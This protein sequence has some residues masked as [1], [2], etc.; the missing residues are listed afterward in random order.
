MPERIICLE[1]E[2]AL[3]QELLEE[4]EQKYRRERQQSDDLRYALFMSQSARQ[5]VAPQR[6]QSH[7]Q[8]Y[9]QRRVSYVEHKVWFCSSFAC[10]RRSDLHHHLQE[11]LLRR[12]ARSW[13]SSE[14]IVHALGTWC[15]V[16]TH[17]IRGQFEESQ[18]VHDT[19]EEQSSRGTVHK[20]NDAQEELLRVTGEK[21]ALEDK[22]NQT[23]ARLA[24]RDA[25]YQ[26][27]LSQLHALQEMGCVC[28]GQ[29]MHP[30]LGKACT[31]SEA[32]VLAND[33]APSFTDS[34]AVSAVI[35]AVCRSC[36]DLQGVIAGL[37]KVED[38][39]IQR[40]KAFLASERRA[41]V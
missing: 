30:K 26:V 11:P 39:I 29:G 6:N 7:R 17:V 19:L 36:D 16:V 13:Q 5:S 9:Q 31:H 3:K 34:D 10:L 24:D 8:Q 25:E 33:P 18:G 27:A 21:M 35:R 41:Q 1:T 22:L 20:Q 38:D 37:V 32:A 28:I 40:E 2:L 15:Q 23:E 4:L 14:Q 12:N